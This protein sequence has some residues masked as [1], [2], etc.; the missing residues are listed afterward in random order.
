M[1]RLI[2]TIPVMSLVVMFAL[3]ESNGATELKSQT[4]VA[5]KA[6]WVKFD[7]GLA[8]AAK[9]KKHMIVDFYTDW[10]HWCKVMDEKTF[11]DAQVNK[12][13]SERFVTVRLAAE[14]ASE[15]ATF[16]GNTYS[17]VELTRAFGVNGFPSLAF[18]D[19][20]GEIITIVPGYVPPET[21]IQILEYI[22]QGCYK[23]QMSFD[24][25]MQ[26]KGDCD[27]KNK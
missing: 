15:Q 11:S 2:N 19:S 17:N 12:K 22:D 20:N 16:H 26:K 27:N 25:F 3:L 14:N 18:L 23:K 5:K 10:C 9:E 7:A 13:L 8:A 1:K 4:P 6:V 21:F 24:E